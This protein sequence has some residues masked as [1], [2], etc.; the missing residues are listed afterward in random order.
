MRKIIVVG[1]PAFIVTVAVALSITWFYRAN[2]IKKNI[3]AAFKSVIIG[4]TKITYDNISVSGFPANMDVTITKPHISMNVTKFANSINLERTLKIQ[5][6]PQWNEDVTID[7]DIKLSVNIFSNKFSIQTNG[8]ILSK[9]NISGKDL[10][11]IVKPNNVSVCELTTSNH[12]GL[13]GNLW[14]FHTWMNDSN[15]FL[16]DLRSADC[17]TSAFTMTSAITNEQ[18]AS[19]DGGRFYISRTP[20]N[21]MSAI[22]VYLLASNVEATKAYDDIYSA[23]IH[24]FSPGLNFISPSIL[25]KQNIEIDLSYSGTE[26]W[27]KPNSNQ[28]PLEAK[29]NKLHIS[30]AAYQIDSS[31]DFSNIFKGNTRNVALNYKTEGT[32]GDLFRNMLRSHLYD[33][34]NAITT[35]PAAINETNKEIIEARRRIAMIPPEKMDQI[36]NSI[37]PDFA[38]L[39]K[40]TTAININYAGDDKLSAYKVNLESLELSTAPYGITTSGTWQKSGSDSPMSGNLSVI[41]NNC[42]ALIDKGISYL[43]ELNEGMTL[44]SSNK[45]QDLNISDETINGLKAFLHELNPDGYNGNKNNLKFDIVNNGQALSVNGKNII[46]IAQI[47]GKTIGPT[48]PKNAMKIP[49]ASPPIINE[50][51]SKPPVSAQPVQTPPAS[52]KKK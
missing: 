23:Y 34:T 49:P 29:I 42:S 33:V 2:T 36:I 9:S 12:S 11:Y 14:D 48:L 20:G 16:R 46:E 31:L 7:G 39:G 43:R 35:N 44:L 18:A 50:P 38:Q 1:L 17:V 45:L 6:L 32:A 5:T 40:I 21:G 51:A 4:D 3:E 52:S 13:F 22:R 19:S 28:F 26:D 15:N 8:N 47:F 25:G 30:N 27:S 37:I 10:S 24:A 41:C